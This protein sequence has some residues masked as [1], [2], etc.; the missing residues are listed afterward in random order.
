VGL[1]TRFR[2]DGPSDRSFEGRVLRR[3]LCRVDPVGLLWPSST[4]GRPWWVGSERTPPECRRLF[5][6]Q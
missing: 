3:L 6:Y 2:T 5:Y 1:H 4:R